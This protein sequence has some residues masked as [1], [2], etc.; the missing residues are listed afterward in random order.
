MSRIGKLPVKLSGG[1][2]ATISSGTVAIEGPKG[3]L[4]ITLKPGVEVKQGADGLEVGV[5]GN[6]W[7]KQLQA[8]WGT[9]RALLNNMV[10]GVTKGWKRSLE[11]SGVGYTASLQGQIMTIAA[12]YSHP[13]KVDVPKEIKAT[14]TKN[15]ID[16]ESC[17][18]EALGTLASAIR[19]IRKPEPYL[20]KGIKYSEE[21][22]R[23]KAGKTGKK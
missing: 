4:Q 16:L 14:V 8:N 13:V 9:T 1:A 12:G 20:G 2:K 18:R 10:T 6:A 7:D 19:R 11:M 22:I 21:T 15:V 5:Q 23:R 3:R 17:D